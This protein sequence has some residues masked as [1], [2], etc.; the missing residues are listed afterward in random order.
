M[1]TGGFA[2]PVVAFAFVLFF[3]AATRFS[4]SPRQASEILQ[5]PPVGVVTGGVDELA[6][7]HLERVL[8]EGS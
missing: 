1:A 2:T 4:S 7:D 5:T 3:G 8:P 6:G